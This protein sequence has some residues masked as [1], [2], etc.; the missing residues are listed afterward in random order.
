[1]IKVL[2]VDDQ[3]IFCEGL[4]ALLEKDDEIEVLGLAGNGKEAYTLCRTHNPDLVLMDIVMPVSNGIEGT[5]LIKS[6]SQ[7]IK[8]IMLTTFNDEEK[9][10]EAVQNG[11]DGYI[12]KD[13][14]PEELIY[15][16]KSAFLGVNVIDK[17][18]F[19]NL[20]NQIKVTR[21]NSE[22]IKVNLTKREISIIKLITEGKENKEI[23]A[24]LFLS[25]GTIRNSISAI[26][27]KLNMK[28]RVQLAVFSVK[29]NL[30]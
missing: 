7:E 8:V 5:K 30:V 18:A 1:M 11:A 10:Q 25:D 21:I 16:V 29:N 9:I 2:I 19:S 12:L 17:N 26:L 13:T 24:E 20:I 4:K 6:Y 3:R 27:Q 15:A 22:K 14:K 28:D 23:A